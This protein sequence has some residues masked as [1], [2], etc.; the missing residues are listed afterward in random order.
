[1]AEEDKT[2]GDMRKKFANLYGTFGSEPALETEGVLVPMDLEGG[3]NVVF[4]IRR[5]GARNTVWRKVYN[6]VMKPHEEDIQND[7]LSEDEN[8]LLLAEV[9]SRSVVV[10]WKG[11]QDS[12]GKDV[13]FTVRNCQ[14]LLEF[15]PDLLATLM[16]AA[17]LRSNF[18]H[19]EME[20]TAKN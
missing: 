19:K 5:A 13:P 12:D 16:T 3:G 2:N 17:H 15:Y 6:E 10:D 7:K 9:Y 14:E 20:Q 18:R 4:K 11:I 1:M 8:K